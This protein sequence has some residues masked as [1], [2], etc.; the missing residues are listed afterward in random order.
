[1]ALVRH[2][3][4]PSLFIMFT[5][6]PKWAAIQAQLLSGQTAIDRPDLVARVFNL[7][8]HDLLDQIKHKR[9]FGPWR[10]WVWTVEYQK[11][12][13]PHVHLLL[14]LKRDAQ[15]LT[16][17]YI[18]RFIS[19]KLPTEDDVIGQQFRGIIQNTMVHTQCVGGNSNS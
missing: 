4:K 19:A 16:P 14:F 12:G 9:I 10:G 13:L 18:D 2:F 5:A 1:M 7:K 8:L 6:N 3:R 17:E 15:L 11:R